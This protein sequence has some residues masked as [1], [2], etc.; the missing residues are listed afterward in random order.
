LAAE[1]W[2]SPGPATQLQIIP[3]EVLMRP[4]QVENFRVRKLD[5]NGLTV[6]EI[7]DLSQV[8]WASFIPPT[9]KVKSTMKGTFN[10]QG[11][12][13]A[14][15][16]PMPSAGAF[17]A[18]AGGLKG[19]IRGRILPYL[20][21]HQDFEKFTLTETNASDGAMFSYPPLP[22]IGARFKFEIRDLN[23]NK[24]LAKTLDNPFFQRATVFMGD[25]STKNYTVEAD[26][27]TEGNKRV[28]S[29]AVG[30]VNQRYYIVMRPATT[31]VVVNSTEALFHYEAPFV[32]LP[33]T[34]YHMKTRVD[35]AEDGSGVIRGK[36]W[37]KGDAEPEAWTIEAH[38]KHVHKEGSPGLFAFCPQ[39][40]AYI[41]NIVVTSNEK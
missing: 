22:W 15:G 34:W 1:Q 31:N 23:G 39:K 8:K 4:G 7:S 14:D 9:A 32:S 21:I 24:V 41:D 25:P 3:S 5:A 12:L 19:F 16:E 28:N 2:P 26:I 30:L 36:L 27:M 13:V 38:D 35:V 11:Q 40:R 29:S 10:D 18:Q 17:M 6:E 20:P 33:N 37:K